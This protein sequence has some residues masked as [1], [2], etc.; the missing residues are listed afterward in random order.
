MSRKTPA[1]AFVL[2]TLA[3]ALAIA[4][5]GGDNG[6]SGGGYGAGG[7]TTE[8]ASNAESSTPTAAPNAEEGATFVS[9]GNVPSLGM[10]LVDSQGFTLYDFH[11]DKGGKSSCYGPCAKI[12]PPLLTE[13]EPHPSNG[14]EADLIGTTER[15]D[16]T[17]QVT[18]DGWPLYTYAADKAPG[19]ANGNDFSSFGGE[20]YALTASGEEPESE[21]GG[22]SAPPPPSTY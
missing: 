7:D 17:T 5:C 2:L 12:W 1:Y 13:G 18:Y 20:W 11:K 19:E 10:V 21:E 8:G 6:G 4:G 14:A 9:L 16:G 15:N 22:A 3:V